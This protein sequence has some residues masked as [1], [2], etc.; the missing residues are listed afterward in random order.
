M[1]SQEVST[2]KSL[3]SPDPSLPPPAAP[4]VLSGQRGVLERLLRVLGVTPYSEAVRHEQRLVKG[5]S[6]R[7]D[8]GPVAVAVTQRR[9]DTRKKLFNFFSSKYNFVIDNF[10][11]IFSLK[12]DIQSYNYRI[13]FILATDALG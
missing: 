12:I 6:A 7:R 13:I 4:P 2:R 11:L 10:L 3:P 8:L 9:P 1:F 5:L